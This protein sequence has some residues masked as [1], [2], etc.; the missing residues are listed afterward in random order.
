M[1]YAVDQLINP[2]SITLSHGGLFRP[3]VLLSGR[4]S[5]ASE[6]AVSKTLYRAFTTAIAKRFVR[7]RAFWVGPQAE[8]LLHQ[9][10]RLTDSA[11]SSTEYDLHP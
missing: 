7:I 5:T 9:G 3:D 11:D 2:H 1:C 8:A 4:V 6:S 10:C